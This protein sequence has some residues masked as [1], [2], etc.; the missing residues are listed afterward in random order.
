[1]PSPQSSTRRGAAAVRKRQCREV[2]SCKPLHG[3]LIAIRSA[4][5]LADQVKRAAQLIYRLAIFFSLGEGLG[6]PAISGDAVARAG[7]LLRQHFAIH[8][9]GAGEVAQLN[10]RVGAKCYQTRVGKELFLRKTLQ[11][12]LYE[13]RRIREPMIVAAG[14]KAHD[15]GP[16]MNLQ[17]VMNRSLPVTQG[18]VTG[19]ELAMQALD[20]FRPVYHE[21][22]LAQ[23]IAKK[24][25]Q[26]VSAVLQ[27]ANQRKLT[28][29]KLSQKRGRRLIRKELA[30]S[31]PI[32]G[33]EQ[34][35][36]AEKCLFG[37]RARGVELL[38]EGIESLTAG[39]V[40]AVKVREP[41]AQRGT[42]L[43]QP[44]GMLL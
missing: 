36:L 8:S 7:S 29:G 22:L 31:I 30:E 18:F 4:C 3:F 44:G 24:A 33:S 6:H 27:A 23:K 37:G 15:S 42:E 2:G 26:F 20:R 35:G 11:R 25:V 19:G 41:F 34:R 1:M 14:E 21:Q 5:F 17:G 39:G 16:V 32:D 9:V 38:R 12:V 10:Q 28:I 40:L 13:Q 43:Q